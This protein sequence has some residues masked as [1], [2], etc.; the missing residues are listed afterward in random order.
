MIWLCVNL[1]ALGAEPRSGS[2]SSR[3]AAAGDVDC[4]FLVLLRLS[5]GPGEARHLRI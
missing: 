1:D 5:D 4:Q 3:V 2:R